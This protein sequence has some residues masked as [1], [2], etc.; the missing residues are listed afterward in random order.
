MHSANAP[1][2][3]Q[4]RLFTAIIGAT[5][6]AV[7]LLEAHGLS[8]SNLFVADIWESQGM[9][10]FLHFI[11][12]FLLI[13]VPLMVLV[14]WSYTGFV[15]ALTAA[16]TAWAAGPMALIG[17]LLF[18]AAAGAVGARLLG[19]TLDTSLPSQALAI[20]TGTAVYMFLMTFLARLP[21]N[22]PFVWVLLL[23][24]P[25]ALDW[26]G[27]RQ[28]SRALAGWLRSAELRSWG[29]RSAAALLVFVLLMHWL[30]AMKPEI[31]AD[32]LAMHLAVP[33]NLAANHRLTFE[34]ARFIW[35]V[36]PMG[37]DWIY[38]IVYQFGGETASRL[39]DFAMLLALEALL[40][41]AVR[42][43]LNRGPSL[44]LCALFASTPMVQ[45]VTGSL[46]VENVLAALVL[47]LLTS[48]WRL[49][50]TGDRRYLFAAAI[51]GGG[52]LTTKF[53]ALAFVVL[54]IPAAA[55][56]IWRVREKLRP[57]SAATCLLALLV[58]AA[59]AAPTYAIAWEKTGNPL[60]P[61][62]NQKFPSPLLDP[63][64]DTLDHRYRDPV[65]W[66]M[67]YDLT[68]RTENYYEARDGSFG[69]QYLGMGM[70]VL[71]GL[72][73]IRNRQAAGATA[74][75]LAASFAILRSTS[76]ARYVYPAMPLLTVAFAAIAGWAASHSRVVFR[77]FAVVLV[78]WIG[79]NVYFLPASGWYHRDF[80]SPFTFS[81]HGA[82]RYLEQTAP[83][84]LV[85][86][87]YS[88]AHPASSLLMVADT[89]IADARGDVFENSW[90]QWNNA[91]AIQQTNN[92][93]GLKTLF[94]KWG[95]RYFIGPERGSGQPL[96]P[97]WLRDF[98]DA[99]T[100]TEYQL[101]GYALTRMADCR[102][103]ISHTQPARVD[104]RPM[105]VAAP[106]AYDDF[107]DVLRFDGEWE[108]NRTFKGPYHHTITFS[109]AA[110]ATVRFAFTGRRVTYVFTR[111]VNRGI[112]EVLLD[113]ADQGGIDLYS[114]ET[115]WQARQTY[116]AA[117][118]QHT[119]EI[120]V[121]GRKSNASS[122]TFVDVDEFVVE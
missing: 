25:I 45:L 63:K 116:T 119:I 40:Y 113:G 112:A 81:R 20:M 58:F 117:G 69:F 82:E 76:N 83:E 65:T 103:D 35:S 42:R 55:V 87:H 15:V 4:S 78:A 43:W 31:S 90:H 86:R 99:C 68:F 115:H 110:G 33:M 10:R 26:S 84:R 57:R 29:E 108:H 104:P 72:F 34:P 62:L 88:Q 22:Y 61:F 93:A 41:G 107:D 79:L 24:V 39:I 98:L 8:A 2:P 71:A 56:E 19:K 74:I 75:A 36:M 44:L 64:A 73:L 122:G 100:V 1:S 28:R 53:G 59:A 12:L 97:P 67:P 95:V 18:L 48:I 118:G 47:A 101:G 50:D 52:A 16:A 49:G 54:A 17:V 120:R 6:A 77:L 11:A 111:T 106:G 14:P 114:A 38:S 91:I 109:D 105:A 60:F 70:L 89:N 102:G 21:V 46:F 51:L 92:L 27:V 13:S 96:N 94:D 30:V 9:G 80:Y 66:H 7:L 85:V 3:P 37:A 23:A 32:G 121:T 5:L